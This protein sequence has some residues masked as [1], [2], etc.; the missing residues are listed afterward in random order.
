MRLIIPD[1]NTNINDTLLGI[2]SYIIRSLQSNSKNIDDCYYSTK[3]IFE[4]ENKNIILD[5]KSYMIAMVF[6]FSMDVIGT[7]NNDEVFL[8]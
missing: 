7:T 4:E 2:G 5:L 3:K 6:L 1:I 8:I